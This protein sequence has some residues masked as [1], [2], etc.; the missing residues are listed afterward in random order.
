MTKPISPELVTKV[1][2]FLGPEGIKFFQ[3]LYEE[4]GELNVVI[5]AGKPDSGFSIPHPVH[6]RE[7]M[8][9]RNCMR[10]SKLC[11]DW[12]D[13]DYDD[14]W[15]PVVLAAVVLTDHDWIK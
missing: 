10:M 8:Q 15:E 9:V 14:M 12:T 7:G 1:L 11:E 3:D 2:E 13:H 4:H 5:S 6:F